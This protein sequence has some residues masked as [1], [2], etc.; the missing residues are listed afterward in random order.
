MGIIHNAHD[1]LF[2]S[3]MAN[4]Q[5]ARDFF[6]QHLPATVQTYLDLNTLELEPSSY[7][8][9]VLQASA[10]DMLYKVNYLKHEGLAYLCILAEHQS[11]VDELMPL[12]LWRYVMS[13]WNE[14]LKKDKGAKLPLVITLV[15]YNGKTRY[16]GPRDIRE[17]I[18]A[19]QELI[20]Q[21]LLKPFYLIDT[22]DIQDEELRKQHWLGLMQFA[23]KHAHEKE[24][25]NCIQLF[26]ELLKRVVEDKG[27][28]DFATSML[29]YFLSQVETGN[30]D[31]LIQTLESGLSEIKE[32][33][34][35]ATVEQY[36]T[37]KNRKIW[38]Q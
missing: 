7:T 14:C 15:F 23:L 36:F 9:K 10:S 38:V 20:E 11:S 22:H 18:D 16:D 30:P 6:Q 29:K 12:R 33:V 25:L 28:A 32:G 27:G 8:D 3:S 31:K 19:P 1:S 24:A 35:M 2:K 5:V 13:V 4:L 26:L 21:C 37:E 17:L 34:I